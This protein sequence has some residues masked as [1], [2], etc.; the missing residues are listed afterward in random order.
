[1]RYRQLLPLWLRRSLRRGLDVLTA[2]R[3]SPL[4]PAIASARFRVRL[5]RLR[6]A[7]LR[8]EGAASIEQIDLA[9]MDDIGR[10][11]GNS[12]FAAD[13]GFLVAVAGNVWAGRGPVLDCGSG[14]STVVAAVI[15]A[16]N[17]DTV[18]SLEQDEEWYHD[19]RR[20]L[21]ALSLRNVVLWYAPLRPYG[22]FVWYDLEGR[23]L[24]ARFASIACDGPAVHRSAWPAPLYERW[25][26][27]VVSVLRE[28][29]VVFD[30][31]VLDD[32]TDS[33][34]PGLLER[35]NAE[36]LITQPVDTPSGRHIVGTVGA[37]AS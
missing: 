10:A 14:L 18:W 3:Y 1:M 5:F 6:R 37:R 34:A 35:W 15:A 27:G 17:G 36:G 20:V 31:I 25:R 19:L 28:R 2:G 33:R 30:N 8:L 9:L 24:P 11:W 12:S 32:A 29:G 23:T 22:D 4:R 7:L 13:S 21:A 16:R 26:V